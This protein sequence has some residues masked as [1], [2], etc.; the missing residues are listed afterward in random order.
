[1]RFFE[2][3]QFHDWGCFPDYWDGKYR[4]IEKAYIEDDDMDRGV[5]NGGSYSDHATYDG[6]MTTIVMYHLTKDDKYSIDFQ[7]SNLFNLYNM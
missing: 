1:M 3:I 2:K 6:F 4:P 7:S 5:P